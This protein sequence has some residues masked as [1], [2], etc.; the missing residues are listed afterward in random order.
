MYP[1]LMKNNLENGLLAEL[2][3]VYRD[4]FLPAGDDVMPMLTALAAVPRFETAVMFLEDA[5]SL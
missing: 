4:H 3:A 1:V 2:F 5:V